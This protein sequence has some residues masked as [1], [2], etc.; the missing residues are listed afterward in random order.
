MNTT[1][2]KYRKIDNPTSIRNGCSLQKALEDN[3]SLDA[4]FKCEAVFSG[5]KNFSDLFDSKIDLVRPSPSELFSLRSQIYEVK[6]LDIGSFFTEGNFTSAG[7]KFLINFETGFSELIDSYP[8]YCVSKYCTSNLLWAH[9]ASG[10]EGFCIEFEFHE[11]NC[12]KPVVYQK[13]IDSISIIE[14]I[15]YDFGLLDKEKLRE[16]AHKALHVKLEEWYPEEEYRLISSKKI[17]KGQKFIKSPYAFEKTEY[18]LVPMIKSVIF[19]CRMPDYVKQFIMKN[20]PFRTTFKKAIAR[21]DSIEIESIAS[22]L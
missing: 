18:N 21:K 16:R 10:H 19:G 5:R 2:Y 6:G 4:L 8:I 9:Y 1:F 15:K 14:F 22:L 17:D 20:L 13:N 12:P 11:N 3:P 7:E